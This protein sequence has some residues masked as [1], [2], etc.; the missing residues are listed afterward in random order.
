MT[1]YSK[2]VKCWILAALVKL[3]LIYK[4]VYERGISNFYRLINDTWSKLAY[5]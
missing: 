1:N 4:I 5:Y 3:F 2:I